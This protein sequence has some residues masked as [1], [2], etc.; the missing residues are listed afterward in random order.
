[1]GQ[2]SYIGVRM[3]VQ[4]G[5]DAKNITGGFRMYTMMD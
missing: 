1:V 3:M 4:H 5:F 2:R